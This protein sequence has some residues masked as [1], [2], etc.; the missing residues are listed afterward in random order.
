MYFQNFMRGESRLF[1]YVLSIL[2]LTLML[3]YFVL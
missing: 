3:K 2:E 1:A